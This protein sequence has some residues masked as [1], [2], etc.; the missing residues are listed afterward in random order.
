MNESDLGDEAV[1]GVVSGGTA[2]CGRLLCTLVVDGQVFELRD[3]EGGTD[4]DWMSGPN[5]GY[6]FGSIARGVPDE[7]H[8]AS[9][10]N[11]LDMIDPMTSYVADD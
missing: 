7:A 9:V 2:K 11:F 5:E 1:P 4:Y 3:H 6:G 8:R 10:R